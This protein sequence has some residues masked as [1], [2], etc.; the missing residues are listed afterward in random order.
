MTSDFVGCGPFTFWPDKRYML[1]S[2]TFRRYIIIILTFIRTMC[3]KILYGFV[4]CTGYI[5]I[6]SLLFWERG[7]GVGEYATVLLL[8]F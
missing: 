6:L 5:I 1:F 4:I 3:C 7:G 8:L 2:S